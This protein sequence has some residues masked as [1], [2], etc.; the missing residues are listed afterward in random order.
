M[1]N[2]L[3][4]KKRPGSAKPKPN[5]DTGG[6]NDNTRPQKYFD[7]N[8]DPKEKRF[9]EKEQRSQLKRPQ[10]GLDKGAPIV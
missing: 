8:I 9:Q 3:K 7:V 2:F 6:W 5:N 4:N 1:P 10:S